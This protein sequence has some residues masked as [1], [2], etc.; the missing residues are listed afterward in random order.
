M[1]QEHEGVFID[2]REF[3]DL[4]VSQENSDEHVLQVLSHG[5]QDDVEDRGPDEK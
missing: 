1:R 5:W 3:W 4:H 2:G